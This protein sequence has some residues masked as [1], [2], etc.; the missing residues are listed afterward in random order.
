MIRERLFIVASLALALAGWAAS[1]RAVASRGPSSIATIRTLP[2]GP[3]SLSAAVSP[4]LA[5]DGRG[6]VYFFG[7]ACGAKPQ[8]CW[9]DVLR[10][11]PGQ[12]HPD[13]VAGHPPQSSRTS[14]SPAQRLNLG[15]CSSIAVDQHGH[16]NLLAAD[17]SRGPDGTG[18]VFS[19]NPSTGTYRE[20]TGCLSC[21]NQ[22]L[23]GQLQGMQLNGNQAAFD[24]KGN[25]YLANDRQH[26]IQEIHPDGTVSVEMR[27]HCRQRA[28]SG[29]VPQLYDCMGCLGWDEH[30][31][32]YINDIFMCPAWLAVDGHDHVYYVDRDS[33]TV[34]VVNQPG[35][36]RLFAGGGR[37][38]VARLGRCDRSLQATQVSLRDVRCCIEPVSVAAGP[39]SNLLIALS[40]LLVEVDRV[41]RMY[42]LAGNGKEPKLLVRHRAYPAHAPATAV[43]IAAEAVSVDPKGNV[44]FLDDTG[45]V[46]QVVR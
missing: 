3:A 38:P 21:N 40:S 41:G 29:P 46:R 34:H 7:G 2:V 5:V 31:T 16:V 33:R 18:A 37:C 17:R 9:C 44:Y 35:H 14:R 12:P 8:S 13:V 32:G 27:A 6:A 15:G 20:R 36:P 4:A 39:R 43:A 45:A 1:S 24:A 11:R 19:F 42:V 25:V 23:T 22:R 10:Q 30:G 26:T 28:N